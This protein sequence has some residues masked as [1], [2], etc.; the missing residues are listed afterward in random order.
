MIAAS[1]SRGRVGTGPD[2]LINGFIIDGT[3]PRLVLVRGIG[4]TLATFGLTSVLANPTVTIVDSKGAV[5][6]SNDDWG[7]T[8]ALVQATLRAGA[9]PLDA[10]SAD[11]AVLVV[12]NPGAYTVVVSGVNGGTGTALVEVYEVKLK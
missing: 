12:L 5:V 8:P 10:N 3:Q 2:V 7:N 9:F 6:G 11:A 4:P 1:A